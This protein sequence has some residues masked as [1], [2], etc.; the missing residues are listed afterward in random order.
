M[1]LTVEATVFFVFGYREKAT[2]QT[3]LYMNL[4]TQGALNIWFSTM[5]P[6][7]GYIILALIFSEVLILLVE[8]FGLATYV[9]ELDTKCT[10]VTVIVANLLSFY[11]GMK[12]IPLLPI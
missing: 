7:Y 6:G 8:T 9:D 5:T 4:L 12:V 1:T 2:Y 10:V 11:V 3:F